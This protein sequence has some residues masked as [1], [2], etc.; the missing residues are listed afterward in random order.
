MHNEVISAIEAKLPS[1]L[2]EI[3]LPLSGVRA[4][5]KRDDL[6]HPAISGNKWRKL[7]GFLQDDRSPL[8]TCGGQHSNHL[9]AF[10]HLAGMI[11]Q[12][13]YCIL[14]GED[15][16]NS[17]VVDAL[18][19][20][21]VEYRFLNNKD[22]RKLQIDKNPRA[23][24]TDF[25]QGKFIPEGGNAIEGLVGVEELANELNKQCEQA[26][27]LCAAC[28]TGTSIAG[29]SA[30]LD[31]RHDLVGVKLFRDGGIEANVRNLLNV[32]SP[33]IRF[34]YDRELGRFAERHREMEAYIVRFYLENGILLDPIYNGRM[35]YLIDKYL[36]EGRFNAKEKELV[37]YHSGGLHGYQAYCN[38]YRDSRKI[39]TALVHLDIL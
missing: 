20:N 10:A 27:C 31:A 12:D 19:R 2:D 32:S 3:Y 38:R 21:G 11:P 7:K 34:L 18:E 28:G 9:Y 30:G 36:E 29:L 25:P 26:I 6:I 15:R 39:F 13:C 37:F 22:Y 5:M 17:T 24:F 16:F 4:R 1:P 23:Y 8:L 14:R 35:L 33:E